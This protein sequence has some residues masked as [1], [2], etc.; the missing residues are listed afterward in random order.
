MRLKEKKRIKSK[1][2]YEYE[3]IHDC[4]LPGVKTYI[5]DGQDKLNILTEDMLNYFLPRFKVL[6]KYCQCEGKLCLG[7]A[8]GWNCGDCNDRNCLS[9]DFNYEDMFTCTKE[10]KLEMAKPY[11][12]TA[13]QGKHI[14]ETEIQDNEYTSNNSDSG[15]EAD[16]ET[17]SEQCESEDESIS[18]TEKSDEDGFMDQDLSD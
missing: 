1:Y 12:I 9:G 7:K 8:K 13:D 18:D 15:T 3:H 17:S 16:E 4:I 10:Q 2:E 5:D 6:L 14:L 11:C